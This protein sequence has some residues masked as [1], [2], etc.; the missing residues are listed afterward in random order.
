MVRQNSVT[1]S[2]TKNKIGSYFYYRFFFI[3]NYWEISLVSNTKLKIFSLV[4]PMLIS[5]YSK[6]EIAYFH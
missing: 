1:N 2:N 4:A 3:L 6:D 5:V